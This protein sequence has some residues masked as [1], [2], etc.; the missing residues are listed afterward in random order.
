MGLFR[1]IYGRRMRALAEVPGPV[2]RFPLGTAG[3][4]VRAAQ[5]WDVCARYAEEYG[6]LTLV[7]LGGRPAVVLN[8][9]QLIEQVLVTSPADFYKK[10][11]CAALRPVITPRS[12]FISNLPEWEPRRRQHPLHTT[13]PAE[14]LDQV[15]VS[16]ATALEAGSA[17]LSVTLRHSRSICLRRFSDS[18]SMSFPQHSGV[19][20]SLMRCTD[21]FGHWPLPAVRGSIRRC[22]VCRR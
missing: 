21:G 1:L 14:W 12:L 10:A 11:P 17:G 19:W 6:G 5:P 15:S 2:P 20:N 13:N 3:D 7:W 22:C 4:F 18:R 9:P 16:T 8:D